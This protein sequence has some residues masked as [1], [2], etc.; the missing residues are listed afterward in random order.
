MATATR[1]ARRTNFARYQ[2]P[3][4]TRPLPA[5]A[6][7]QTHGTAPTAVEPTGPRPA[8]PATVRLLL[9]IGSTVYRVRPITSALHSRA[10]RLRRADGRGEYH[11]TQDEHGHHCDCGDFTWRREG[12]ATTCKHI[13]ALRAARMLDAPPSP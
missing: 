13:R 10:F 6:P 3:T 5:A 9:A 8:T 11:V 12:T 7:A 2:P 1:P 4:A